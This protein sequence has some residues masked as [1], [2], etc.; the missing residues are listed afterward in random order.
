MYTFVKPTNATLAIIQ[1][2]SGLRMIQQ[3]ILHEQ[4]KTKSRPVNQEQ[5]KQEYLP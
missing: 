4:H 2:L 1:E 5:V 3:N